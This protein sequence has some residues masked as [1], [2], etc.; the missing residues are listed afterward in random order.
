MLA[1]WTK[2]SANLRKPGMK[3]LLIPLAAAMAVIALIVFRPGTPSTDLAASVPAESIL[4][5]ETSDL[6]AVLGRI[7]SS[8]AFK[9]AGGSA[10]DLSALRGM[11]VA[12]AVGG[13]ELSEKQV[14]ELSSEADLRPRFV[15]VAETGLWSWQARSFAENT[16]G[17][18]VTRA[19]GD[20]VV[21]LVSEAEQGI[22]FHWQSRDGRA[23]YALV[24]G[25]KVFFSNDS[26]LL[27]RS[28]DVDLG[29][30]PSFA[31]NSGLKSL[32]ESAAGAVA[33]GY[34]TGEGVAQISN[35]VGLSA[36]LS[37]SEDETARSFIARTLPQIV[38]STV[39]GV[40][41]TATFGDEGF[42]D[43]IEFA[44][45]PAAART[46]VASADL[47]A[48]SERRLV[49]FVSGESV[50]VTRYDMGRPDVVWQTVL[51]VTSSA[52]DALS[53]QLVKGFAGALVSP[54]AV[55]DPDV[56]L[57]SVRGRLLTAHLDADGEDALLVAE[58]RDVDGV[59]AS[60][61]GFDFKKPAQTLHGSEFWESDDGETAAAFSGDVL[62]V[63]ERDAVVRN[64]RD[65]AEGR[66]FARR[67]EEGGFYRNAA[68]AATLG[69]E[70]DSADRVISALSEKRS[71]N[72][73]IATRF[74]TETSFSER[75]LRRVTVSPF[76][77]VG[78]M[79]SQFQAR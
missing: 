69:R 4:F 51:E 50:S 19:Y 32:R 52:T 62:T 16:L 72:V 73:R 14:N 15:A 5:L 10:P 40:S 9:D 39:L 63:G 55:A 48:P 46:L 68:A 67:A 78:T 45:E 31:S 65:V 21:T 38:R 29:R 13:F 77:F 47:A 42:I 41:W 57:K 75:G 64:L 24:R 66:N 54:F 71:E 12:V 61:G 33:M 60:L 11:R 23:S 18:F 28:L 58:I 37:A 44:L 70:E 74:R 53:G 3:F 7:T 25:S 59:K 34:L 1:H 30:F 79:V 8:R 17:A 6:G 35:V 20:G 43:D 76:G 22:R 49:D 56:F 2:L 26:K 27:G 36:A